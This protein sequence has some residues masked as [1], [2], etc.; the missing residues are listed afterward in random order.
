MPTPLPVFLFK[1]RMARSSF[2]KS[3]AH[4][5]FPGTIF[6]TPRNLQGW[7][8]LQFPFVI[9][10]F[11]A[12]DRCGFAQVS[13]DG[14]WSSAGRDMRCWWARLLRMVSSLVNRV[15]IPFTA[16]RKPRDPRTQVPDPR[17]V[18]IHAWWFSFYVSRSF[19]GQ[20][21]ASSCVVPAGP[22]WTMSETHPDKGS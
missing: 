22:L 19:S 21:A 13:K 4:E 5:R 11:L 3:F 9:D 17:I 16:L 20:D 1:L 10:L 15:M 7:H 12:I 18:M 14:R 2:A 8:N 6:T